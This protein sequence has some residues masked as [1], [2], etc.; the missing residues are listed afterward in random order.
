M[1]DQ[2]LICVRFKEQTECGEYN[3]SLYYTEAEYATVK[4][5]DIDAEKQKRIANWV[6]I[7]KN[8]PPYVE[9]SKEVLEKEKADLLKDIDI[10]QAKI[11]AK[12]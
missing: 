9:P 8:P 4:Q 10:I 5:E 3:D 2:V 12:E 1:A 11:D 7:V 6:H